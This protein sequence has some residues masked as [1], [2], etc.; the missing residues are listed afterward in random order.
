MSGADKSRGGSVRTAHKSPTLSKEEK[1]RMM[2][3]RMRKIY[4][5]YDEDRYNKVYFDEETGGYVVEE[6]ARHEKSLKSPNEKE[7]YEKEKGMCIDLAKRGFKIEHLDDSGW[8]YDIHMNKTSADLKKLSSANNIRRHAKHAVYD[9]KAERVVFKFE[10]MNDS[11]HKELNKLTEKGI[12][13]CYYVTG[14]E[15]VLRWF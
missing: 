4:D 12:H 7:K 6:K 2:V 3:E 15:D 8:G 11:I 13:G 5:S 10:K 14:E 1:K 9:Q